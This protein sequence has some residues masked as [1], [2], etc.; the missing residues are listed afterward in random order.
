MVPVEAPSLLDSNSSVYVCANV[1]T[2]VHSPTCSFFSLKLIEE[3]F[4]QGDSSPC[5]VMDKLMQG[6]QEGRG[7]LFLQALKPVLK[8]SMTSRR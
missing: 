6:D 7:C 2:N 4:K 5:Q 3:T 8:C 1:C